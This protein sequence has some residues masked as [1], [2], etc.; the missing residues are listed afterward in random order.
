MPERV[1][2]S[3]RHIFLFE[4]QTDLTLNKRAEQFE[5]VFPD[6][7]SRM[8]F[9]LEILQFFQVGADF[10][11][12]QTARGDDEIA[13]QL[14]TAMIDI[15]IR[16]GQGIFVQL[17][18]QGAVVIKDRRHPDDR[19]GLVVKQE[20]KVSVVAI[21]IQGDRVEHTHPAEVAVAAESLAII[22]QARD[23]LLS[24]E[25]SAGLGKTCRFRCE[26]RAFAHKLVMIE[27]QIIRFDK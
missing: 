4:N 13:S 18:E 7:D 26:Q 1:E 23:G 5:S 12:H 19:H 20:T 25:H 10:I 22:Q 8:V 21:R 11:C 6:R 27:F 15:P 9:K 16:R 2:R 3:F 14:W 24:L 17:R